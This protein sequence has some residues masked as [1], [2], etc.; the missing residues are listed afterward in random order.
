MVMEGKT[1]CLYYI[2][3]LRTDNIIYIGQT[4]N[5][6]GR[7]KH[8]FSHKKQHIDL[9]MFNEG[10]YN[11]LMKMFN[12][13]CTNL[14]DEDILKKEDELILFYNTIDKGFNIRRS[15]LIMFTDNYNRNQMR[16]YR[17]ENREHTT[18]YNKEYYQKNKEYINKR[19]SI[20]QKLNKEKVNEHSRQYRLRKRIN[21]T[22]E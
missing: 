7:K 3:D 10:R 6:E 2:K 5:F 15:G 19:K 1:K 11:F 12:I 9:Y 22:S 18:E 20:Y 13:D 16:K 21:N 4:I 8:H 17:Q 14:S